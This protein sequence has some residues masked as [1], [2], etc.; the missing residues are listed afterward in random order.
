M[1]A[2][3]IAVVAVAG[4]A[5]MAFLR[6]P[7]RRKKKPGKLLGRIVCPLDI[8][9]VP[10]LTSP[11]P[12]RMLDTGDY[13]SLRLAT[14]D[15]SYAE[16][17]WAL[18]VEKTDLGMDVK[19][20]GGLGTATITPPTEAQH[21]YRIGARFTI[22]TTCIF[23][24]LPTQPKWMALCGYYA[25]EVGGDEPLEGALEVGQDVT[26]FLASVK[27]GER[28]VPAPGWNVA[29]PSLAR[30]SALAGYGN[31]AYVDLLGDVPAGLELPLAVTRDCVFLPKD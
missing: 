31:I 23:A 15:G 7:R 30:V 1:R 25:K 3:H 4:V 18:V 8:G 26:V 12:G 11:K 10:D 2:A 19:L 22:P 14:L 17:A 9:Y 24:W 20:T 21:G 16:S 28:L 5:A 13:V 6:R 29:E 27:D